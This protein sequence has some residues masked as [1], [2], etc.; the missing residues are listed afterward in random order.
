M[1]EQGLRNTTVK[2]VGWS[3]TDSILNQGITFLVGIVLARLLSPEEYGLLGILMIFIVISEGI[4]NSGLSNALIRKQGATE[5]DYNTVFLTN[6]VLSFAMYG[7]LFLCAPLIG[8][9]FDKP[10]LSV[11]LRVIGV[12]VILNALSLVPNAKLVKKVDFKTITYCSFTASV[13]SGVV[14]ISMALTGYGV[15]ALVGQQVVRQLTLTIALWI[16]NRWL[17]QLQFSVASFKELWGFGW[18]LLVSGL[19]NNIWNEIYKVVIGKCYTPQTLGQYTQAHFYADLFSRNMTN[20]IQR[21]SYPVLS[22]MQDEKERLK[23]AYRQ[24]IKVTMLVTFVFM[25]GLAGCAKQFIYVLIGDQWLPCV[26]YL[27]I[28]CLFM[29]LYPLHAINLNML[30]V[31]GRSDLFLKLEII[32]KCIG[33]IPLLLGI[34]VNIYWMLLGTVVTGWIAYYLN[35]YYSGPYLDYSVLMQIRDITPSMTLALCMAVVVFAIGLLPLSPYILLPVQIITGAAIVFGVCELTHLEEYA[36]IK[37]IIMNIA[38]KNN[39]Q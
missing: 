14:G 1:A 2:G 22:Q 12:M 29:A 27:Q 39:R 9:F 3:F 8:V 15:W 36:E 24:V 33:V 5:E 25:F 20:V 26:H 18:K 34:F 31:Q 30:Q 16:A 28:I 10:Q 21:V 17:P 11:L 37:Q 38:H 32:K 4:V 13:I 6:L 23:Q 7:V 19:I 35:A